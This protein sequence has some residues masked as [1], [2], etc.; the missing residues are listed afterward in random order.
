MARK[1]DAPDVVDKLLHAWVT[2]RPGLD[3]TALGAMMRIRLLARAQRKT[4]NALLAD[5]GIRVWQFD[6]LGTLYAAGPPYR[7]NPSRILDFVV[8]TPGAMTNRIDRLEAD[9]LVRREPDPDD[10][11]AVVVRLTP[12]GRK[13]VTEALSARADAAQAAIGTLT[14]PD[15]R[16]LE[17]LLR[18]VLAEKPPA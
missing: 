11:R 18:K 15:M 2:G 3:A 17:K 1:T 13:L 9:N 14:R 8:L 10:R 4:E 16:T 7:L 5:F 12:K 6:V